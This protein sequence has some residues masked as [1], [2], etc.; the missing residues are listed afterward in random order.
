MEPAVVGLRSR[1]GGSERF[2]LSVNIRRIPRG[3]NDDAL[4]V[5][6]RE[7]LPVTR[8]VSQSFELSA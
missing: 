6:L 3:R 8:L 7:R 4:L 1:L 5:S 2:L